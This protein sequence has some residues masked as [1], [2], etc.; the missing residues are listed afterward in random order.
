MMTGD[1]KYAQMLARVTTERQGR[2]LTLRLVVAD[3][4]NP[5]MVAKTLAGQGIAVFPVRGRQPLTDH[6]VYSAT[7]DLDVLCRMNWRDANGCGLATGQV[8]DIDVLDVDV[9]PQVDREGPPA[10]NGFATLAELGPLPET[11]AASSPRGGH[12]YSFRHIAGSRSH[13]LGT[14]TGLEWFSDKK[15]VAVPPAP[16]RAWIDQ[17]EIAQAPDWLQALVL[18]PR[19]YDDREEDP[20]GPLVTTNQDR[21]VPRDIYFLIL[22]GMPKA[23]LQMTR[24]VR[25]LWRN[26]ADKRQDRNDGLNYTAWQFCLFVEAGHLDREIAMK[27]VYLACKANGYLLKDEEKVKEAI[28]RVLGAT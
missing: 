25:G 2:P 9:R 13:K 26:L 14:D 23:R 22:K 5:Y 27:L 6:G 7:C 24:Q 8:N 15:L 3:P 12:H 19:R 17:A 21:E 10:V 16:G 20:P 18:S 28:A 11:L 1:E 4:H